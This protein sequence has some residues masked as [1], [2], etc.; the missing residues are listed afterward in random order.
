[1]KRQT[2]KYT[3]SLKHLKNHSLPAIQSLARQPPKKLL[4]I[5]LSQENLLQNHCDITPKAVDQVQVQDFFNRFKIIV[6]DD[7]CDNTEQLNELQ[8]LKAGI[9]AK[10]DVLKQQLEIVNVLNFYLNFFCSD[11]LII[12]FDMKN[13]AH[14]LHKRL[15]INSV[16]S[17]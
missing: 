16:T 12:I 10:T 8:N 17:K 3:L 6:G 13:S 9:I 4:G 15:L 5:F 1:M 7:S 2:S 14:W 11:Q